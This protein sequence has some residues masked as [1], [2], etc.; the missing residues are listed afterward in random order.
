MT[1]ETIQVLEEIIH[2][3]KQISNQLDNPDATVREQSYY[4]G[5]QFSIKK[6]ETA[7]E[8]LNQ[9]GTDD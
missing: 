7:L 9:N 4:K 5:I 3:L 1:K 2:D 6:I 8:E